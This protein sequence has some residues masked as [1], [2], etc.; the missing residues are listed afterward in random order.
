MA[1]RIGLYRD[2]L[3]RFVIKQKQ[4]LSSDA[5]IIR[6][7]FPML[8]NSW[9]EDFVPL[10]KFP[11]SFC[12]LVGSAPE[13]LKPYTPIQL[14]ATHMDLLVKAYPMGRVSQPLYD[15]EGGDQVLVK[16]PRAKLNVDLLNGKKRIICL[17]AGT[18]IAPMLQVIQHL[19][20]L[21][22]QPH[23][24]EIQLIYANKTPSDILL[25]PEL[26]NFQTQLLPSS[27]TLSIEHRLGKS[28]PVDDSAVRRRDLNEDSEIALVCGPKGF[29]DLLLGLLA[30]GGFSQNQ[31]HVF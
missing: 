31:I 1:S 6:L 3:A 4:I 27:I 20:T 17:A 15:A 29:N 16:G 5:A 18:G 14:T 12:V 9:G 23:Q 28:F 30:K 22:P 10:E 7:A 25:L 19:A 26:H 8:P 21:P 11:K 13:V 24:L 2:E